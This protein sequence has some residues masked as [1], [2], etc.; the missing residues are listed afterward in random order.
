MPAAL[1]TMID[2]SPSPMCSTICPDT[3]ARELDPPEPRRLAG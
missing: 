3:G 1:V 2:R